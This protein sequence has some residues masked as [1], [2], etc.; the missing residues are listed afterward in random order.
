[1]NI[2]VITPTGGRPLAF[3][4]CELWM[5]R[6]TLKPNQWIVVDDF[7]IPTKCTM[8]QTI[9]R[10]EPFWTPSSGLT[11][12]KNLEEALKIVN[13]DIILIMEDDDW[14]H[15]DY[16]KNMVRK[17]NQPNFE[18]QSSHL[19]GAGLYVYYNINNFT[20]TFHNNIHHSSLSQVAFTKKLI[21]QINIILQ[22]FPYVQFFDIK[23][24]SFAR[25][26]K[27]VFLTKNPWCVG[28]KGL[29]GRPGVMDEHRKPA[30]FPDT[31]QLSQLTEWI[32]K[33]DLEIYKSKLNINIK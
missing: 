17:F 14:Y 7:E 26:N 1:M 27:T 22:A 3:E 16:I 23:L 29:P 8:G 11:L 2:S 12:Q 32:G 25:C 28:I 30:F 18:G 33:D 31:K 6:Q 4:L 13:G 9:I 19:I 24:W 5:S 15:Q 10:R 21:K 20:Y